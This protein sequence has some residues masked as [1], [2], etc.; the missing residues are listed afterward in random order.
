MIKKRGRADVLP[1][2]V[3]NCHS[4]RRHHSTNPVDWWRCLATRANESSTPCSCLLEAEASSALT[5]GAQQDAEREFGA[6]RGG[7]GAPDRPEHGAHGPGQLVNSGTSLLELA[8][9]LHLPLRSLPDAAVYAGRLSRISP[10][11]ELLSQQLPKVLICRF[12][13]LQVNARTAAKLRQ[14]PVPPAAA[15]QVSASG[16]APTLNLTPALTPAPDPDP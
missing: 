5:A 12:V 14:P 4:T 16:Q 11:N 9:P 7:A 2:A 15:L 10:T 8:S 13:D 3:S 1:Y 6:A